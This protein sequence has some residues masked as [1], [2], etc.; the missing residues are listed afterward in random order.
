MVGL[1]TE[2]EE[3]LEATVDLLTTLKKITPGL[4][5]TLGVST[6]VPKAHTPFQWHG[7]LLESKKRL[8]YLTKKLRPKGIDVRAESFG[9]SL[10]QTLLSRSDR[11]L[12]PVIV[13]LRNSHNSLGNWKNAYKKIREEGFKQENNPLSGMPQLP[14]WE[15]IV[16]ENWEISRTLP[17]T[18]IEGPLKVKQLIDHRQQ[19]LSQHHETI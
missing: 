9:W 12:A 10:I 4:R 2:E 3:D 17:W 11:R 8:N 13:S 14:S 7:V 15:E 18:H 1:P 16:H 5:L 6:F 19:A